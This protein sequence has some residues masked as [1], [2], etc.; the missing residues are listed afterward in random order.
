[1]PPCLFLSNCTGHV[2]PKREG[3]TY[4]II[5]YYIILYCIALYYIIGAQGPLRSP[6]ALTEP[7]PRHLSLP[8]S[9]LSPSYLSVTDAHEMYGKSYLSV[10]DA[11]EMYVK[12][13]VVLFKNEAIVQK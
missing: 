11:P 10:A 6:G 1:M 8:V 12:N 13:E 7:G 9:S 5:L 3:A 2:D 4:I